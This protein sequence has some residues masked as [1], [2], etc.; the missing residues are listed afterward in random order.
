MP[1]ICL[2]VRLEYIGS[3]RDVFVNYQLTVIRAAII[4]NQHF[5][6][7]QSLVLQRTQA[8][9]YVKLQIVD[10]TTTLL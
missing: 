5:D 3:A 8:P 7:L 9:V 2:Y 1:A 4:H 10:R 6:I